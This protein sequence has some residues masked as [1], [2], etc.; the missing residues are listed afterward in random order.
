MTQK[1][2][3]DAG[4]SCCLC[5]CTFADCSS[6]NSRL[7]ISLKRMYPEINL[8]PAPILPQLFCHFLNCRFQH[9]HLFEHIG[10]FLQSARLYGTQC[11]KTLISY[12]S[13]ASKIGLLRFAV[14][15]LL[16]LLGYCKSWRFIKLTLDY[17]HHIDIQ[18]NV[19][20]K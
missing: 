11:K 14:C 8:T 18:S 13:S 17:S 3:E 19:F 5:S 2:M 16:I 15:T 20:S 12:F 9:L 1:K 6:K 10:I 7:S 4:F